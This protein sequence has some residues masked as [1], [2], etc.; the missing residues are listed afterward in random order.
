MTEQKMNTP[1][2]PNPDYQDRDILLKPILYF[3]GGITLLTLLLLLILGIYFRTI[4]RRTDMAE[5]AIPAAARERVLPPEPRLVVDEKME[6]AQYIEASRLLLD[7]YAVQDDQSLRIPIAHAMQLVSE[8]GLPQWPGIEEIAEV[9]LPDE[10]EDIDDN[11]A[12]QHNY[13]VMSSDSNE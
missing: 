13:Q 12:Q 9:S 4:D 11:G 2:N 8:R 3:L 5:S 10:G 1:A 6:L 7:N